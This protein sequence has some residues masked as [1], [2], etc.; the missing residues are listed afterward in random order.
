[1]IG[2]LPVYILPNQTAQNINLLT[3]FI[4]ESQKVLME[5]VDVKDT[6]V[7]LHG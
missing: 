1:M 5:E 3:Q 6:L 2:R 4:M 7:V